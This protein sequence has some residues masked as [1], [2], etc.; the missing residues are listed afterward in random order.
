M[1]F[2]VLID[3]VEYDLEDLTEIVRWNNALEQA[4]VDNWEGHEEAVAI[5]QAMNGGK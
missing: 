2:T 4:G 1:S 5:Y 3:D